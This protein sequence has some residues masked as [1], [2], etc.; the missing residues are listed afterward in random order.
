MKKKTTTQKDQD[1]KSVLVHSGGMKSGKWPSSQ[2]AAIKR[3]LRKESFGVEALKNSSPNN[4]LQEF[5]PWG[6][7]HLLFPSNSL[8]CVG[9]SIKDFRTLSINEIDHT[10]KGLVHVVPRT[11]TKEFGHTKDGKLSARCNDATGPDLFQIIEFDELDQ[12]KQA[13]IL[14]HLSRFLPLVL[15]HHSGR[16]S[17]HGWFLTKGIGR[18]RLQRFQKYAASLGADPA[19]FTPSQ[20]GRIPNGIRPDTA[21][22]QELMYLDLSLLDGRNSELSIDVMPQAPKLNALGAEVPQLKIMD[23][24]EAKELVCERPSELVEGFLHKGCKG[25]IG[26]VSKSGK[27][28]LAIQLAH[29]IACGRDLLGMTTKKSKVVLLNLEIPDW[30][31][32]ERLEEIAKKTG[33]EPNPGQLSVVNARGCWN[34]LKSVSELMNL[35][36]L[37]TGLVLI[38]PFYKLCE[39]DEIDQRAVKKILR[40]IDEICTIIGASVLYVHHYTKGKPEGKNAIDLLAGSNILARDFDSCLLLLGEK[41]R[42]K[43]KFILRN[44]QPKPDLELRFNYPLLELI[45]HSEGGELGDKTACPRAAIIRTLDEVEWLSRTQLEAKVKEEGFGKKSF[46]STIRALVEDGLVAREKKGKTIR[47]SLIQTTTTPPKGGGS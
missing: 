19:L 25:I 6:L 15:V 42:M 35:I 28:H 2:Q 1:G 40:K 17:L 14:R 38:D 34:G 37:D 46:D 41:S 27:S 4:K 47:F 9:S 18:K 43:A 45:P 39:M 22:I 26:G 20:M 16:K 5:P 32:R 3:V 44:H 31:L 7:L 24:H 13:G 30:A 11:M 21:R 33:A 36:P 10:T 23:W 12:D 29:A 8:V